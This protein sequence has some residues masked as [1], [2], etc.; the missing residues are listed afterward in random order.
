MLFGWDHELKNIKMNFRILNKLSFI[1]MTF[2]VG[3]ILTSCDT[4]DDNNVNNTN[5]STA[6]F[7]L[8]DEDAIDNGS[9]PNNFSDTD[10]NDHLAEVGQR[11]PLEWFASNEGKTVTL[12]TGQVGDE[13]IFAMKNIP[14][15]WKAA[16]PSD[17]GTRNFLLAGPG[18]GSEGNG[19]D[20]EDLL[21]KIPDV[22]P[23]RASGLAMLK[24]SVVLAVVYDSDISINYSPLNGSLKGANLGIAAFEVLEV[25]D[26]PFGSSSS[27]PS[28]KIKV[29]NAGFVSELPLSLF[30]NAPVVTSSS[31]PFDTSIA[32]TPVPIVL[33]DAP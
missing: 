29:L 13:G 11:K 5:S 20:K 6:I 31:E 24:G 10:V 21:D 12:Y 28:I 27:L 32:E 17:N 9:E 19:L 15:S 4:K 26:R 23:L 18:M 22:T 8:I 14:A 1:P 16:G 2:A 3:I 33:A 7:L 25:S 30:A